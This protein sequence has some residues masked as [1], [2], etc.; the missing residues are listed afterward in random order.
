M[1][2]R[3]LLGFMTLEGCRVTAIRRLPLAAVACVALACREPPPSPAS[4]STAARPATRAARDEEP[5]TF[6][7]TTAHRAHVGH[8]AELYVPPWFHPRREG[9]D[10]VV[11]FHGL[12]ELQEHNVEASRLNVAIVSVNLGVGTD[13]YAAA[14]RDPTVFAKLL[15]D[16]DV[17]LA[18]S[19]RA[20]GKRLHRLA[21]SAWSAGFVSV[22]RVLASRE[23]AE[24]VDAVL[25]ADGFFTSY[26]NLEKKTINTESLSPFVA[27]A[28]AAM[29]REK[30]FVITH[31]AIPT[32]G[33]PSVTDTVGKLLELA[34][35]SR[36]PAAPEPGPRQM[37]QTYAVDRGDFHV[38]GYAGVTAADHVNQ[39]RAMGETIYPLLHDRWEPPPR[40]QAP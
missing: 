28:A 20:G 1:N 7:G 8:G 29:R 11:H 31:T 27:L 35:V 23:L 24:K 37:R 33:Y 6:E 17:E 40:T 19:G 5:T 25:L 12:R 15:D 30:L 2:A 18:K 36:G 3:E 22:Q 16:V 10:L 26:T 13:A 14:F 21:L 4:S 32:T 9:Y 38:H 39:V 34:S